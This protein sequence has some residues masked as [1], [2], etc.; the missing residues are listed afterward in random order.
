MYVR[1][2]TPSAAWSFFMKVTFG[3]TGSSVSAWK[4]T[5]LYPFG[6]KTICGKKRSS[7]RTAS[8]GQ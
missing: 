2:S 8:D 7:R 3:V 6:E 5:T 1:A 4:Y